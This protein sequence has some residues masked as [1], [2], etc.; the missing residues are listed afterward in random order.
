LKLSFSAAN[1]FPATSG[2]RFDQAFPGLEFKRPIHPL[3]MLMRPMRKR[4]G[5]R[6]PAHALLADAHGVWAWAPG[7]CY[8]AATR[9]ASLREWMRGQSGCDMQ[10]WVSGDLMH[11]LDDLSALPSGDDSTLRSHARQALVARHGD[12]AAGW[13]LATWQNT[14]SLGVVALSGVDLDAARGHASQFDV[15]IR[16]VAPWW[17]HAFMEARQCV[18]ALMRAAAARVCVVEG[19][20]AAWIETAHG[21]MSRVSREV[22]PEASVDALNALI[23]G[24]GNTGATTVILGQGLRDGGRSADVAAHVLG[25]LDSDQPPQWLRPSTQFQV[26]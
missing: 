6:G 9:H 18:P 16:S 10:L 21:V 15:R 24:K 12:A 17:H 8:A 5:L 19:R 4:L 11:D 26:H 2:L 1:G 25:R 7:D 3:G 13:P 22:L 14:A 20:H 23:A